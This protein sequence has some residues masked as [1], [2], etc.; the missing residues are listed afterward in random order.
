MIMKTVAALLA[1]TLLSACAPIVV[2]EKP[3]MTNSY[4]RP[5]YN[6]VEGRQLYFDRPPG[7]PVYYY[8]RRCQCYVQKPVYR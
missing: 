2:H 7:V 4:G 5:Y 1:I 3:Q 6:N 8:D